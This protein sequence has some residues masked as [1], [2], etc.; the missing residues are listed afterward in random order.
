MD[1]LN[2]QLLVFK[3]LLLTFDS[4]ATQS[5]FDI[6]IAIIKEAI[7]ELKEKITE[8]GKVPVGLITEELYKLIEGK[9]R[10]KLRSSHEVMPLIYAAVQAVAID[11]FLSNLV[12][13]ENKEEEKKVNEK[14]GK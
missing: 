10:N 11:S 1:R 14:K 4:N 6:Y 3:H 13:I 2:L 9:V 8:Q 5:D 12:E 7:L